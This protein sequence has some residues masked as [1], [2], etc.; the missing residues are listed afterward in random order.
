LVTCEQARGLPACSQA[1]LGAV[2]YG[3]CTVLLT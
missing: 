1:A 2:S 3:G